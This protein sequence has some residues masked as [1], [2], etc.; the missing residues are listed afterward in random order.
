M[1]EALK[2]HV[3]DSYRIGAISY[4]SEVLGGNLTNNFKIVSEEGVYFLKQHRP[5]VASR[6]LYVEKGEIFLKDNGIPIV[7]PIQNKNG[8]LHTVFENNTYT[9]YPFVDGI[10][11]ERKNL[12][13]S[14]I[15]NIAT[16]L[17]EIHM[18]SREK[19]ISWFIDNLPDSIRDINLKPKKIASIEKLIEHIEGIKNKDKI[20]IGILE[21]LEDKLNYVKS[22][23]D[24]SSHFLPDDSLV[25]GD[26]HGKNVFFDEN[27]N[28]I[29]VF[30]TEKIKAYSSVSDFVRTFIIV[31]FD[32]DYSEENYLRGE[33]FFEAY[34]K[35]V[36]LNKEQ[37]LLGLREYQNRVYIS[38]WVEES[39]YFENNQKP[40]RFLEGYKKSKTYLLENMEKIV[41]RFSK[42]L[43]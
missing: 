24:Y 20:D 14:H 41:E 22:V 16:M 8:L 1:Y 33:Y 12:K 13:K 32:H 31:C 28:I 43:S 23:K 19:N 2:N 5:S 35:I 18:I 29:H 36:P 6:I 15:Q 30:D 10:E 40:L 25:H 37:F 11:V 34:T 17:G 26:F 27:A 3:E 4:I 9:L 42:Y 7:L 38:T 21:E 39:Y